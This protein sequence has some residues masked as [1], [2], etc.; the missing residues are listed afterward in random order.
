[1]RSRSEKD[2]KRFWRFVFENREVDPRASMGLDWFIPP[3]F[4]LGYQHLLKLPA[5]SLDI[6]LSIALN[7]ANFWSTQTTEDLEVI[8]DSSSNM[9]REKWLWDQV[10]CPTLPHKVLACDA[11]DWTFPFRVA[12]TAF[13]DSKDYKQLQLLDLLAGA[14]SEWA[15][16]VWWRD[17]RTDY[18]MQLEEAGIRDFIRWISWPSTEVTPK[19]L[20][21]ENQDFN[22][23]LEFIASRLKRPKS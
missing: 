2:Y 22:E 21:T 10:V 6:A 8:H 5:N 11:R 14:T 17:L 7:A 1:M 9:A 3:Y 20:G 4:T 12:S 16:E 23:G 15:W 19:Q 18:L 13:A